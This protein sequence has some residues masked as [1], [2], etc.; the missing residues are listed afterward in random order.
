MEVLHDIE[1]G[2]D[3][4]LVGI[5]T[6]PGNHKIVTGDGGL[7]E[8]DLRHRVLNY[9]TPNIRLL[10]ITGWTAEKQGSN[11]LKQNI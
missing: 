4:N 8:V 9:A 2:L 3:F 7:E 6:G 1:M 10:G 11:H 5:F